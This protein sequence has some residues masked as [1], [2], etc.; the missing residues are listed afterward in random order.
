MLCSVEARVPFLDNDLAE[1]ALSLPSDLKVRRG[2]KKFILKKALD[3]LVPSSVLN[4]PKRG[5]DVPV[6][7]WLTD[8]LYD[9]ARNQFVAH[10]MGILNSD[11]L[12]IAVEVLDSGSMDQDVSE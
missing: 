11:R 7:Q 12:S 4:A 3:G 5:F 10:D 9:F 6:R 1:F 2:T 8:G